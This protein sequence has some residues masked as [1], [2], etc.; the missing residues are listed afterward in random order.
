MFTGDGVS[1]VSWGYTRTLLVC[2]SST[3]MEPSG[4]AAA[5]REKK[6][7][8][9]HWPQGAGLCIIWQKGDCGLDTS[10]QTGNWT[11]LFVETFFWGFLIT[12][13][14]FLSH[15]GQLFFFFS[16]FYMIITQSNPSDC[17][18]FR[19]CNPRISFLGFSSFRSTK[20]SKK[21]SVGHMCHGCN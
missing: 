17:S 14:R 1:Q 12:L 3:I 4:G 16:L 5:M 7:R 6:T 15:A 19:L 8:H 18:V 9:R 11:S 2:V 21:R 20:S 13:S 10:I